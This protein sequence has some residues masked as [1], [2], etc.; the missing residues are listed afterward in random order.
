MSARSERLRR[1]F[2]RLAIVGAV[3]AMMGSAVSFTRW[4]MPDD[5]TISVY[6]GSKWVVVD[7]GE[8]QTVSRNIVSQ[9]GKPSYADKLLGTQW[10]SDP[11]ASGEV[12]NYPYEAAIIAARNS[13]AA[14]KNADLD[15]S[16][17]ALI[18]G[19]GWAAF[20]LTASWL[21]RGFMAD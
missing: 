11:I 13:K 8:V 7:D 3:A 21:I 10:T 14:N 19:A 5:G 9:V 20:I 4:V 16:L 15:L 18:I 12:E 6:T 1:G 17:T 2:N